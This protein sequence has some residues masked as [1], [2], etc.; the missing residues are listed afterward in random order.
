MEEAISMGRSCREIEAIVGGL[1][2]NLEGSDEWILL[3]I[4]VERFSFGS[5]YKHLV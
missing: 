1:G 5:C 3:L 4:N 2:P